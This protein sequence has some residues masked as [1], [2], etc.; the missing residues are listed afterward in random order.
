MRKYIHVFIA[1]FV[2]LFISGTTWTVH[3]APLTPPP[4]VPHVPQ[5]KPPNTGTGTPRTGT[6]P[7]HSNVVNDPANRSLAAD[8]VFYEH[9]SLEAQ[10][11]NIYNLV[12]PIGIFISVVMIIV[13]GYMYMTST[14]QP[15]KVQAASQKLTSAIS[16]AIFI[17]LSL[18]ILKVIINLLL[19]GSI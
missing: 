1:V 16:G 8:P 19:G 12:F 11:T 3:G 14:G 15:D 7:T 18:V 2:F 17:I 6:A 13:A 4:P 10:V 5:P 9:W